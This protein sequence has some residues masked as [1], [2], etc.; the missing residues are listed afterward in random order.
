MDQVNE[1][2]S[3]S[4]PKIG[5]FCS[6]LDSIICQR[7]VNALKESNFNI[8]LNMDI[9][10]KDQDQDQDETFNSVGNLI[11]ALEGASVA[12]VLISRNYARSNICNMVLGF[13]SMQAKPVLPVIIE[14][15]Y[16]PVGRVGFLLAGH[17][18][19]RWHDNGEFSCFINDIKKHIKE[20]LPV[21]I[22]TASESDILA[23]FNS[24]INLFDNSEGSKADVDEIYRSI[25]KCMKSTEAKT[26]D[27]KTLLPIAVEIFLKYN[28]IMGRIDDRFVELNE[29]TGAEISSF[30][31]RTIENAAEYNPFKGNHKQARELFS[32][33]FN[34]LATFPTTI[35]FLNDD[36]MLKNDSHGRILFWGARVL[37]LTCYGLIFN[38]EKDA[39]K[40]PEQQIVLQM[41]LKYIDKNIQMSSRTILVEMLLGILWNLSANVSLVP[42][43]VDTCFPSTV[44]SWLSRKIW[45]IDGKTIFRALCMVYNFAR[46]DKGADALNLLGTTELLKHRE[47]VLR[48]LTDSPDASTVF[49]ITLALLYQ[50]ENID[51]E[52]LKIEPILKDLLS[53]TL[54][55][56]RQ[57]D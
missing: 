53:K 6:R 3:D 54:S 30:L 41:W 38:S 1:M 51:D 48:K 17:S 22:P 45:N 11:D 35:Y 8:S 13:S 14:K 46:H 29:H 7:I 9:E 50:P 23:G 43:F 19:V 49:D 33:I 37:Q 39:A 47:H 20:L 24:I 25:C 44:L 12:L 15:D 18:Y 36:F 55:T 4:N 27:S 10:E 56:S 52:T 40:F 5:V 2:N 34:S 32:R 16:E 26:E 42:F 28:A 57:P 31:D 21:H